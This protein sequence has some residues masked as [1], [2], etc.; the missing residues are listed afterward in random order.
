MAVL[1]ELDGISD[2]KEEQRTAL[3]GFSL[4]LTGTLLR[5]YLSKVF[6]AAARLSVATEA[7]T[8]WF[9]RSVRGKLCIPFALH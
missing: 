6:S 2:L 8:S 1:V 3:I 9:Q 5:F 7:A 4:L